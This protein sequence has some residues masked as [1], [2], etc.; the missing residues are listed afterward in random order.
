MRT[1]TPSP[2][3]S[4]RR[5]GSDLLIGDRTG[6][7][8]CSPVDGTSQKCERH[9]L[10]AGRMP[11][12][13]HGL[14]PW[15]P[16]IARSVNPLRGDTTNWRAGCGRS[17]RPVRREGG[18]KP[19]GSPYPYLMSLRATLDWWGVQDRSPDEITMRA[20]RSVS[21]EPFSWR[22]RGDHPGITSAG[23]CRCWFRM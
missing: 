12:I 1:A 13:D 21:E 11:F 18:P 8:R 6:C 20:A 10:S 4:I 16:P 3:H 22:P 19:I 14:F 5:R 17:A 15:L 23:C 9:W 7:L 2:P